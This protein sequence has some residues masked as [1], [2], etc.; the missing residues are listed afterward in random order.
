MISLLAQEEEG[1]G[2]WN[3]EFMA[4]HEVEHSLQKEW[5]ITPAG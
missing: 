2:G 4:P 3:M 1:G 5:K